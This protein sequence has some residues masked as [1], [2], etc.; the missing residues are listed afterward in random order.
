MYDQMF[1]SLEEFNQYQRYLK[2]SELLFREMKLLRLLRSGADILVETPDLPL[3]S[4]AVSPELVPSPRIP[5]VPHPAFIN[6]LR[7]PGLI[8]WKEDPDSPS[9]TPKQT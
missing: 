2:K 8:H 7:Q 4:P 3:P 1:N 5:E 6:I 9:S